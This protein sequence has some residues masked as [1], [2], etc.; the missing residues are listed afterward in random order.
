MF[1]DLYES[2]LKATSNYDH[3]PQVDIGTNRNAL[4]EVDRPTVRAKVPSILQLP[5]GKSVSGLS[6][7]HFVDLAKR[8]GAKAI[9]KALKNLEQ[10]NK[11][12]APKTAKATRKIISRLERSTAWKK[13]KK[14]K[15]EALDWSEMYRKMRRR[16]GEPVE[17]QTEEPDRHIL[18][19][20]NDP[21]FEAIMRT[22]EHYK[23]SGDV[24]HSFGWK[25]H[26]DDGEQHFGFDGDGADRI[27]DIEELKPEQI[28]R[29][30]L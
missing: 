18:I 27:E 20:V 16:R 15:S 5:K 14:G 11:L 26:N 8:K 25:D 21:G 12:R 7:A 24:G 17:E 28:S 22:L 19:T 13:A 3:A 6:V 29:L 10:W 2:T 30:N 9:M 4:K 1:L 23:W